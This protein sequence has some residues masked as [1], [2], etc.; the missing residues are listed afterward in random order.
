MLKHKSSQET[1]IRYVGVHLLLLIG[2]LY[3]I[4]VW[5][6]EDQK[7][8]TIKDM[9]LNK[10]GMYLPYFSNFCTLN[11]EHNP[12]T[13]DAFSQRVN[14]HALPL[15]ITKREEIQFSIQFLLVLQDKEKKRKINIG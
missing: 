12:K 15:T 7:T 9:Y 13:N 11:N 14:I 1:C 4:G 8:N 10:L 6:G 3:L 2:Q 5:F